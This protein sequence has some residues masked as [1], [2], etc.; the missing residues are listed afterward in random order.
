MIGEKVAKVVRHPLAQ[1]E[2]DAARP[3]DEDAQA[4]GCDLLHEQ[5]LDVGLGRS[6]T[7]LDLTLNLAHT[8]LRAKKRWAAKPTSRCGRPGR[9]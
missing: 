1:R 2:I 7:V 8:P 6:E 5:H 4:L 3:V 9:R